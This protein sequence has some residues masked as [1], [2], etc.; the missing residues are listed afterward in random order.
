MC[1]TC[2]CL[3]PTDS[4][5]DQRNITINQLQKA[6]M[7]QKIGLADVIK[8]FIRTLPVVVKN[9]KTY[10]HASEVQDKGN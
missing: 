7:A 9:W 2:G 5:G 10:N 3:N 4:H 1:L 8:N 6:A